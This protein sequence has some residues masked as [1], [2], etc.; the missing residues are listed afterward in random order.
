MVTALG[1]T[2]PQAIKALKATD[3][4][5]ERAAD[6]V[7]SHAAELDSDSMDT[8][9]EPP[10]TAYL[11]GPGKYQ[12]VAFVSHMGTSTMCG[13]Y[14]CHIVKDGRWVIY[15]DDKVAVSEAPPRELGYLYLYQRVQ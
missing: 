9:Q 2:R 4:N 1:F 12:L 15:N 10:A 6:W 11:D 8:E 13:H 14:V 3:N 7:F 5:I